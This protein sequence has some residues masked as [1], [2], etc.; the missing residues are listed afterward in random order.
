MFNL[1]WL[2]QEYLEV[3]RRF[4]VYLELLQK[5]N[6]GINLIS[7]RTD[8]EEVMGRHLL[9]SLQL[10]WYIPR[11]AATIAD[12]G[13]GNGFPGLV[14][15]MCGYPVTLIERSEKKAIFLEAVALELKLKV[16]I[17]NE[18]VRNVRNYYPD[19]IVTR[20][21][22]DISNTIELASGMITSD[23]ILFF[24]KSRKQLKEL[25]KEI[26]TSYHVDVYE[27][28]CR[29]DGVIIKLSQPRGNNE[30]G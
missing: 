10:N 27:N 30:R 17:L 15:A 8:P 9:D 23:T 4:E 29:N 7:R 25:T 24:Y 2:E 14:L 21:F 11:K 18:D 20:A 12:I 1:E 16:R 13:A 5:W 22:S 26:M 6:N 19:Y 3:S 28:V